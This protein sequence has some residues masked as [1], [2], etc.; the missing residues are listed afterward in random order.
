MATL[1]FGVIVTG[2][3]GTIAGTI[4]SANKSGPYARGWARGS[5]PRSSA[6]TATRARL[7]DASQAWQSLT[8]QQRTDWDTWAADPA[9]EKTNPLGEPYYLSGF[10]WFAALS[11][12]RLRADLAINNPA[13][14]LP[15]N[16]APTINSLAVDISAAEA[17]FTYPEGDFFLAY[18]HITA[19]LAATQTPI[20]ISGPRRTIL[21]PLGGALDTESNIYPDVLALFGT[22][23]ANQ[24]LLLQI[25]SQNPEGLQGPP[26]AIYADVT[27]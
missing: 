12:N 20:S 15:A 9:Q 26:T 8:D 23:N 21:L 14:T 11:A 18:P 2:A 22:L 7:V 5:N 19:A 10:Q 3:R 25:R 16:P 6:Q 17:I 1:K 27:N 13:P 4:F 24:R